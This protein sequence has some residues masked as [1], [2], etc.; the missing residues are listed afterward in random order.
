[1]TLI[2]IPPFK[3]EREVLELFDK[4]GS[5]KFV[6][7]VFVYFEN[8]TIIYLIVGVL[9]FPIY[10]WLSSLIFFF[11]Y[12]EVNQKI[13]DFLRMFYIPVLHPH[14]WN[15]SLVLSFSISLLL[16]LIF[17]RIYKIRMFKEIVVI[18]A[19]F[20]YY[21]SVLSAYLFGMIAIVFPIFI[22]MA[23]KSKACTFHDFCFLQSDTMFLR[24]SFLLYWFYYL[25][26][27]VFLFL[28]SAKF[29]F[30]ITVVG[31]KKN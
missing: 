24:S 17:R 30:L 7:A 23:P 31:R 21:R 9:M 10:L 8:M 12:N 13:Y 3:D 28:S 19:P 26:F 18:S 16:Y 20:R 4:I 6:S 25:G 14:G 27:F 29:L 5:E 15:L 1:M 22:T 11:D 2:K